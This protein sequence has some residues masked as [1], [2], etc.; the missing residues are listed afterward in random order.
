MSVKPPVDEWLCIAFTVD[1][2]AGTLHTWV[3]GALVEGLVIDGVGT[4]DVDNQ[5]LNMAWHP[6][7]V[8]ARFGWESYGGVPMTLWYDD[9]ALSPDPLPCPD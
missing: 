4:P 3:D 7:L 8:D 2:P 1:G 6:E 9:I 5:W